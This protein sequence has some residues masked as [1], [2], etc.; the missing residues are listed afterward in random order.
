MQILFQGGPDRARRSARCYVAGRPTAWANASFS[1]ALLEQADWEA[2]QW[3]SSP[4][5]DAPG[6]YASQMRKVF[7]LPAAASPPRA[8]LFLALPGYGEVFL[9]GQR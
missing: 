9:N 4:G 5:G 6:Q 7:T 8:R 3:I 1:T 2:S